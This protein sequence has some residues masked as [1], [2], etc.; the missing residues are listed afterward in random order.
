MKALSEKITESIEGLRRIAPSTPAE[1]ERIQLN[2][3]DALQELDFLYESTGRRCDD[4]ETEARNARRQRDEARAEIEERKEA[5]IDAA[6]QIDELKKQRDIWLHK[7][8]QENE[9]KLDVRVE[10]ERL[11]TELD[12]AVSERTPHDYGLLTDQRNDYR[13]RLGAACK[14]VFELEAKVKLL[15]K[16]RDGYF[17]E[18]ERMQRGWG[19]ANQEIA[20]LEDHV[21]DL[22][23]AAITNLTAAVALVR[24]EPSRLEV[25]AMLLANDRAYEGPTMALKRADALI[26]AAKE[27]TK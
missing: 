3:A 25:A 18:M 6:K 15:T 12:Q 2:A 20:R 13:E 17:S 4:W 5:L 7:A 27:V 19:S 21:E 26:A 11:K 23:K 8:K 22:Q 10:L 1:V 9:K 24:P 16:E 14:E